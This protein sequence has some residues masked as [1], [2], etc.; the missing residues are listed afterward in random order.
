MSNEESLKLMERFHG[1]LGPYVAIGYR[2]G[3]MA[4]E[5][6][7]EG[8]MRCAFMSKIQPPVSCAVDG[9]QLSSG[10][11][12]GKGTITAE[13]RG[14]VA[15]EFTMGAKKVRIRL[16]D[17]AKA[18]IDKEMSHETERSLA[19]EVMSMPE[20]ELFEVVA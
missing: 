11:T 2:M 17:S 18:R 16:K 20:S 8:K 1:H 3:F 7:G 15:A 4:R 9:I 12:M 19:V 13:D 5:W 6:F 10:C 14:E